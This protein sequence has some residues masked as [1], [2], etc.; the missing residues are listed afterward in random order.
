MGK[1]LE[2]Y[3]AELALI[4]R[5]NGTDPLVLK[6]IEGL[7]ESDEDLALLLARIPNQNRAGRRALWRLVDKR[8]DN[9]GERRQAVADSSFGLLGTVSNFIVE[10]IRYLIK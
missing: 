6:S 10:K 3:L 7:I 8:L 1:S 4:E 2:G 5:E 9:I